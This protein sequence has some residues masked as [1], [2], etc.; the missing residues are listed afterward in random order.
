MDDFADRLMI[1]YLDPAQVDLLLVPEGDTARR[2]VR[3][4]LASVYEPQLLEVKSVDSVV[5]SA[6]NFQ[7]PVSEPLTLLGEWEKLPPQPEQARISVETPRTGPAYWTDMSLE[8]VVSARTALTHGALET[9]TSQEI[10]S[11]SQQEFT[12]RFGFLDLPELMRRSGVG[13]YAELQ[14]DFSRLY[15]L[16]FADPPPFDPA[17][18]ART[19]QLP[20]S[21][22]FFPDLELVA[23]LRR[24]VRSRRALNAMRPHP[25]EYDGGAILASSAWLAVFPRYENGTQ[26]PSATTDQVSALLESEGFV[27]A[28]ESPP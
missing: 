4:L 23:A 18:P 17:A 8:T 2:R 5:V 10:A 13:D 27:A 19:Y 28:F 22:L 20:I 7:V 3:A 11:L 26:L 1:R 21:V 12:E 15:H 9:I 14:A 6:K 25:G 24:L 16:H